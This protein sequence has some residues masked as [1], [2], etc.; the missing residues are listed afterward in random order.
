MFCGG[1]LEL[2][3]AISQRWWR[4]WFGIQREMG[5]EVMALIRKGLKGAGVR[6]WGSNRRPLP[7]T[8]REGE[9]SGEDVTDRWGPPVS[10]EREG[11]LPRAGSVAVAGLARPCWALGVAQMLLAS[12]FFILFLFFH[13]SDFSVLLFELAKLI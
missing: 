6:Y 3:R 5:E 10:G 4:L 2:R 11:I 12:P 9:I 8:E 13:F 1:K 7:L